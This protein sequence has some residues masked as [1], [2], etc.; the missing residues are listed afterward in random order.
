VGCYEKEIIQNSV[1]LYLLSEEGF[2][3]EDMEKNER[4]IEQFQG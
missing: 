4:K 3:K 2:L 1:P